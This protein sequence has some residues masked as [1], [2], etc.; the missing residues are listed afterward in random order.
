MICSTDALAADGNNV[1]SVASFVSDSVQLHGLQ[2]ARL[3]CP[4]DSPGKSTR[5]GSHVLL[6][7]SFLTQGLNPFLLCLLLWQM[8]S[9]PL[10]PPEKPL[11]MMNPLLWGPVPLSGYRERQGTYPHAFPVPRENG[12]QSLMVC[13][14]RSLALGQ[15]LL[16]YANSP[17]SGKHWGVEVFYL[18]PPC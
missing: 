4:W 18:L 12:S 3:F 9:I 1:C 16:I 11:H 8:G 14:I 5:V 17:S 6:Q 13:E 15:L 10:A 2:P 7:G